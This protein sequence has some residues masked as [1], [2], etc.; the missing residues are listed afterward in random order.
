M[1]KTSRAI[2]TAILAGALLLGGAEAQD[3]A[4][5]VGSSECAECHEAAH[6]VW[7]GTA[8]Q[9]GW[10][11][12]HR[13]DSAQAVLDRMGLRS[14]RRGVCVDCH[15]TQAEQRGRERAISGV[16]CESCHSAAQEWLDV[17]N[18]FGQTAAGERAT[19]ETETE[20]HRRTRMQRT[21]E[22]G[23]IRPD[24]PYEMIRNCYSCHTVPNEEL[25]NT[26]QHIAGSDFD[27]LERL[28]QIRH[29]FSATDGD[30][31][32]EAARTYDPQNRNRLLFVLGQMVDLEYALRGLAQATGP[33]DYADSMT[34]RARAAMDRLGSVAE[35]A[36]SASAT[37]QE[38]LSA[39]GGV[40]LTPG[41]Q[42]LTS[43]ADGVQAAARSF[44]DEHD[45]SGLAGVDA[46]IESGG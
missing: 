46:M 36:P 22:M 40:E 19:G 43:A 41:N 38:A 42:A 31:N 30:T 10:R 11:T 20:E 4:Q 5:V 29:N 2:P 26:G 33:G 1:K 21:A 45:G 44:A 18:D 13:S 8:H 17:H 23:M 34:E 3:P 9:E 12:F 27:V 37:V 25:V 16:A 15:Y 35:A 14:A 7:E 6:E 32:R 24:M 39:A 28:D